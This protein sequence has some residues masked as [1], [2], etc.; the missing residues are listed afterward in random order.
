[1]NSVVR[2][3]VVSMA[4]LAVCTLLGGA[5]RAQTGDQKFMDQDITPL[6]GVYLVIKDANVRTEPK[7]EASK[8]GSVRIGDKV[9]VIGKAK[10]GA[11]WVAIQQDGKD[12]GF[13]YA[14]A[15]LPL[16]DGSLDR[17]ISGRVMMSGR[18][19]CGYTIHFRGRNVL[20]EER[21]SFADYEIEYRCTDGGKTYRFYAPMFI[22]EVPYKLTHEPVYQ[23]NIDL[24]GMDDD[25]DDI[26]SMTF[27]YR[28]DKNLVVFDSFSKSEMGQKPDRPQRAA[29]TVAEALAGAAETA[30]TAWTKEAW[31][32]L[33]NL[34]NNDGE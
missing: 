30:P 7:T 3:C 6:K 10:G 16:L 22:T 31:S 9:D 25:P 32:K 1:M 13:V 18:S 5:V 21:I 29:R 2:Y 4:G 12:F 24:L 27:L 26:F 28:R 15:L 11:G 19:P 23:I 34:Y 33:V 20:E 17:D 8:V 14:P